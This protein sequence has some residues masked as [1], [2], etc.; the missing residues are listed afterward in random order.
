MGTFQFW[1]S[2]SMVTLPKTL[3]HI[4]ISIVNIYSMNLP[5]I[6]SSHCDRF[7]P[8]SSQF[9]YYFDTHTIISIHI[10]GDTLLVS[11]SGLFFNSLEFVKF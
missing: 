1:A 9:G 5:H 7:V 2:D 8:K 6:S 10:T 4:L 3:N 11:H